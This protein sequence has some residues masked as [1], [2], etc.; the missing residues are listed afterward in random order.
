[1]GVNLRDLIVAREIKLKD[2][3]NKK[4]GIDAYNWT[5]QFLSTIRL[6]TGELLMDSNGNVTSH[7]IGIF[8]RTINLLKNGIKPVY[9]WDG[10]PPEFKRKTLEAREKVKLE[11]MKSFEGAK[12]DEERMKYAQQTSRLTKDM[13]DEANKLLELM[14]VPHVMAPSEGEA[15]AVYMTKKGDLWAVASQDWDSLLFGSR[16]LIRNLSI[17]GKR[18]IPRTRIYKM[19]NPEIINL[20]DNLN[21]LGITREQLIIIGMLIGT[22]Y[23]SGVKGYGPKKSFALVKKEKTLDNVLKKVEWECNVSPHKIYDWFLNPTTTDDYALEW[24]EMDKEKLFKFLVDEHEFSQA[25]VESQL[26]QISESSNNRQIGLG[27]FLK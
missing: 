26:S 24:K 12:T 19:I 9:V 6:R 18:K 4:I 13:I 15:Q 27:K 17:S 11:A 22:D 16:L 10:K 25:R 8:N 7:L 3:N 21:R 5:Y 20:D 14:G 23:C 2:I 1:M